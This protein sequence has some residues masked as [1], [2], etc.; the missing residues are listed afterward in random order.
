MPNR[1]RDLQGEGN[2]DATR[3]Y[4]KRLEKHIESSDVEGEAKQAREAIEGPEAEELREAER[5]GK[6][7]KAVRDKKRS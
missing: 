5:A 6:Q 3:R 2:Y 4:R 1:D 7:G